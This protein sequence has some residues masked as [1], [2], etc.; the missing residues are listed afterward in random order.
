[1]IL[2]NNRI[3]TMRLLTICLALLLTSSTLIIH[4]NRA[5]GEEIIS[6]SSI[7][8]D[9]SSLNGSALLMKVEA[10][11]AAKLSGTIKINGKVA[12]DLKKTRSI[13]LASC[14]NISTCTI[15]VAATYDPNSLIDVS[16]YS[17]NG[18]MRSTQQS[19]GTG[20]LRQKFVLNIR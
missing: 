13:S 9:R 10:P 2:F 16:I 8:V 1:M 5:F 3:S 14:L 12:A 19:T 18:A 11:Q 7:S 17:T 20:I 4:P 6:E 15:D